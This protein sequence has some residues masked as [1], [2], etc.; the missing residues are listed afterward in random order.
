MLPNVMEEWIKAKSKNTPIVILII[1]HKTT[2]E[3]DLM[4][5]AKN[6]L[7]SGSIT[8]EF[9]FKSSAL[10]AVESPLNTLKSTAAAIPFTL[11]LS[12]CCQKS[13]LRVTLG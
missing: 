11:P 5:F 4:I 12:L 13:Q 10:N 2:I 1:I 9:Y 6:I 8:A 3:I 7:I